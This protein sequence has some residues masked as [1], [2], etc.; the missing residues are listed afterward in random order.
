M[1]QLKH[2]EIENLISYFDN[3]IANKNKEEDVVV[4][5]LIRDDI[6]N[7]YKH[8]VE[9]F[10]TKHIIDINDSTYPKNHSALLSCYKSEGSILIA[11][12]KQIWDLQDDGIKGICQYCG[13][14]KPISFDHYLPIS[15][16]PEYSVLAINLIPCCI[17]CNE[18]KK[19]YWKESGERGIINFYLDNISS[20]QFLFG[21]VKFVKETPCVRFE[22]NNNNDGINDGLFTIITNHFKRLKLIHQF[23]S[24]ASDELGAMYTTFTTYIDKTTQLDM[25]NKL[26]KDATQLQLQFGVN[27][28]KAVMRLTLA[29][30]NKYLAYIED[31]INNKL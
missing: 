6:D 11:L 5:K 20:T 1:K 3:I 13:I 16:Y 19:S 15:V 14:G 21:K 12:K 4:L 18:K 31:K 23:D 7:K 25:K 28:W 27:Y 2:P 17:D 9:H 29:N 30:S 26:I 22:I 24:E 8:Y 10:D